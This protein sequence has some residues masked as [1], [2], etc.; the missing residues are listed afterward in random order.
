MTRLKQ[1][2]RKRVGSFPRLPVDIVASIAAENLEIG[3]TPILDV[4][5]NKMNALPI[6]RERSHYH[7]LA[8]HIALD[9]AR[10]LE[11]IHE[12]TNPTYIHH[13]I[14]SANILLD[15]NLRAKFEE[16]M[17]QPNPNTDLQKLVDPTLGEN[18]PID[19]VCE[20]T[21]PLIKA[22]ME[23]TLQWLVPITANTI[24]RSGEAEKND[25]WEKQKPRI[26]YGKKGINIAAKY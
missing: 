14:K 19:S 9:S 24:K 6:C 18:Y 16:V 25:Y 5:L 11:Y 22:K 4:H 21:V 7:G 3:V 20:L 1:T 15:K 17:N 10:G 26:Y 8:L 12:H 2:Q 23:E 13:D